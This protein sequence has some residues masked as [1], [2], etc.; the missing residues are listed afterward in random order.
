[1]YSLTAPIA[2]AGTW[3]DSRSDRE[4]RLAL[5]RFAP[6][7]GWAAIAAVLAG[8]SLGATTHRELVLVLALAAAA[9]NG[10]AMLL[11]WGEWL[12]ALRG[13]VLLDLWS[14]G[15]IGLV[16]LLVVAGGNSF[17][18]LSFLTVPFIGVVH[19]DARRR[20]WLGLSGGTCVL[21]AAATGLPAGV[22]AMRSLLLAAVVVVALVLA[23]TIKR[24]AAARRA[25]LGRAEL[26]RTF[27]A[28][29]NHR[30]TNNLQTLADL[31]LLERPQDSDARAFDETAARIRSIA[32]V[33]RLLAQRG[34]AAV[35]A[36]ALLESIAD[37]APVPVV[38]AADHVIFDS[39]TAQKVGLLANELI[40]N[41]YRHG[42]EPIGVSLGGRDEILLRV[43]DAGSNDRGSSGLGLKLVRQI[44]EHGLGGRFELTT[45]PGGGTRAEVV[46]QRD[47]S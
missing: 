18:L 17:S 45:P 39:A 7:L 20:F 41:A 35:D 43:D 34:E 6:W 27:A 40:T 22:A 10:A 28:E 14:A 4:F 15:L 13:R 8:V 9:A 36:A 32:S 47:S 2:T 37:S 11:P 26:E 12:E 16:A 5:L 30:I 29:A 3:P 38:V 31:L 1:M 25:A 33:H 24:E 21:V 23:A 19:V 46:F 42:A 44:A